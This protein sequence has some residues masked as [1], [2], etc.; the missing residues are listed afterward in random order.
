M[1]H[2]TSNLLK[3]PELSTIKNICENFE[4]FKVDR[5]EGNETNNSYNRVYVDDDKLKNY[6]DNLINYLEKNID[7]NQFQILEFPKPNTWIN[8]VIPE[9]NQNDSF[10]Y[11][12][13]FLTAVTYLNEDFV[14]GEFTYINEFGSTS[15]INPKTNKIEKISK[16]R[17]LEKVYEDANEKIE[18]IFFELEH[19]KEFREQ[20]EE[21]YIKHLT[22]KY[23]YIK[24]LYNMDKIHKKKYKTDINE[25]SYNNKDMIRESWSKVDNII[26]DDNEDE[27]SDA[28]IDT[29]ST[30]K[31]EDSDNGIS[32][33]SRYN[34][35]DLL[36]IK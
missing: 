34:K 19:N 29:E 11:D 32:S 7:K 27:Y 6:Y 8:K 13:S 35:E 36:N 31:T 20:F 12:M 23:E 9:T 26:N 21:K 14:G 15:K 1:I 16:D 5:P 28:S 18:A 4:T 33:E 22:E 24:K 30:L 10:H 17:F 3:E 25:L 2:T